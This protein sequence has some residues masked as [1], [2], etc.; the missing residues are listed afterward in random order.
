[1][2]KEH[3]VTLNKKLASAAIAF[4]A[5]FLAALPLAAQGEAPKQAVAV[6]EPSLEGPGAFFAK[7]AVR[8]AINAY[9][10]G[11]GFAVVEGSRTDKA[12]EELGLHGG[13]LGD[14]FKA[15]ELGRL[16]RA[17]YICTSSLAKKEG[18][19]DAE[20]TLIDA[21]AGEAVNKVK[22]EV[23][24]DPL[25]MAAAVKDAMV[26]LV[27]AVALGKPAPE[28]LPPQ[29]DVYVAGYE[30][31]DK[32]ELVPK[33]WKNGVA[34]HLATNMH[35]VA[36]S[37]FLSGDDIY[38]AGT[39]YDSKQKNYA[40]LWK[41]GAISQRLSN[42]AF[43]AKAKTVLVSGNDILVAGYEKDKDG[44]RLATLWK[45][46]SVQKRY[47]EMGDFWTFLNPFFVSGN[48]LYV[49]GFAKTV[50]DKLYPV[51]WKNGAPQPLA[52]GDRQGAAYRVFVSGKD[53]YVAGIDGFDGETAATA[54]AALWKNGTR[55]NLSGNNAL[56]AARTVF[57][58]GDDVYVAGV[59]GKIKDQGEVG[60]ATLWTN[61]SPLPLSNGSYDAHANHVYVLNNIA[62]VVGTEK[63]A[64]GKDVATLWIVNKGA[65]R[66][67]RLSDSY[68]DG[69]ANFVLAR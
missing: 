29:P 52:A 53:V 22:K 32:G 44:K 19:Y 35:G 26:E 49:A 54:V 23:K 14:P 69:G 38:V 62:Y 40:V 20:L 31:G 6:I 39:E 42:G 18:F 16:L 3:P 25:S 64:E 8:V 28:P 41:N 37:A 68:Y 55:Q 10:A 2:L 57:V 33:L 7:R 66:V 1:L 51:I 17:D 27:V 30:R 5:L 12:M 48:D 60:T 59:V 50:Q 63:N 65:V 61:G 11:Y 24:D 13:L 46:G 43:D 36:H 47:N 15:Q 58:S 67:Q 21:N 34:L 45:N 9:M 4:A 56:S